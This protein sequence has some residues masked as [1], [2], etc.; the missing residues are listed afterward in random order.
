MTH[1]P[2][3]TDPRFEGRRISTSITGR[4]MQSSTVSFTRSP[5]GR[6]AFRG[7][8]FFQR[9]EKTAG[10]SWAAPLRGSGRRRTNGRRRS[11]GSC[12][13]VPEDAGTRDGWTAGRPCVG[14]PH[15]S[16]RS[17]R[18]AVRFTS[19]G[20]SMASVNAAPRASS[21]LKTMS[22]GSWTTAFTRRLN[23]LEVT[24]RPLNA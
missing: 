16:S 15:S 7:I 4:R 24:A 22:E 3:S 12:P 23:S 18:K 13:A 20:C 14:R 8:V 11:C 10:P 6:K 17:V 5:D 2:S 1:G 19:V 9:H 21:S